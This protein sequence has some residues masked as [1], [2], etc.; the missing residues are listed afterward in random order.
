MLAHA[1]PDKPRTADLGDGSY[2][3]Q[4]NCAQHFHEGITPEEPSTLNDP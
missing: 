3:E 4:G 2:V 1:L